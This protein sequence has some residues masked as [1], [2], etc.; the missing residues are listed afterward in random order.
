VSLNTTTWTAPQLG[1]LFVVTGASGTGKTTLVKKALAS[2]PGLR[3]SVSA[4]T[5]PIRE[6]ET[7]GV[8][9]HFMERD[10]FMA[11]VEANEF[12]E[13]AEVYGNLYG[14]LRASVETALTSG[15]SILLDIDTQGAE[16]VR[17]TQIQHL[18][19]FI[20]PPNLQTLA[21]RL[22]AR[23]TDAAAVISLRI[24]EAQ[25]QLRECRHFD[26]VVVNDE[27]SSAHDQFQA[28]LVAELLRSCR[29]SDLIARYTDDQ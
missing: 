5:R 22:N 7:D 18:S 15:E 9:Y 21:D 14:T 17:A 23:A 26:Y 12:L 11:R 25:L 10:A 24:E 16:Q 6:G 2:I 13:W 1:A 3:F 29:H 28:I 4:T 27:L 19:V 20:L 8:D